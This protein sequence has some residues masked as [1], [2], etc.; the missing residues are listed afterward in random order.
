MLGEIDKAALK[1][2]A[3]FLVPDTSPTLARSHWSHAFALVTRTAA[4]ES[5]I[6]SAKANLADRS[7]MEALERLKAQRDLAKRAIRDGT[8]WSA[9]GS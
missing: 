2:G 4:L 3:P 7:D 5:E 8:I 9:G 1:S 6:E